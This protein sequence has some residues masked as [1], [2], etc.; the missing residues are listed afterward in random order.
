M[1]R[2]CLFE[3]LRQSELDLLLQEVKA[4]LELRHLR[5]VYSMS[6]LR[7]SQQSAIMSPTGATDCRGGIIVCHEEKGVESGD[8][9]RLHHLPF[10]FESL[11]GRI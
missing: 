5:R 1:H 7:L 9:S 3:V 2:W 8:R 6:S 4:R 11:D 10:L